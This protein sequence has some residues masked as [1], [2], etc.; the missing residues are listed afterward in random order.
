MS[1]PD[2]AASGPATP[3]P[4]IL[5]TD[6]SIVIPTMKRPDALAACLDR[7]LPQLA[8][9]DQIIVSEDDRERMSFAALGARYPG[10]V[11]LPGPCRGPAANRNHGARAATRPWLLFLDDDCLPEA[12][13]LAEYRRVIGQTPQP[14]AVEGSIAA[15][16]E[17]F[18]LASVSPVN[19]G[20]GK[21]WTCNA[22]VRRDV[23]WQI[24]GFDERFPF[25]AMEDVDLFKR[26]CQLGSPIPFAAAARVVHPWRQQR[27]T[28]P[29]MRQAASMLIYLRKYPEESSRYG[30]RFI[31]RVGMRQL[32]QWFKF[33]FDR[34]Y[35]G[36]WFFLRCTGQTFVLAACSLTVRSRSAYLHFVLR[37]HGVELRGR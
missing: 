11:W 1:A 5:N 25:A 9:G 34:R 7:L 30:T 20:G 3:I 24:D 18:D 33:L 2:R 37:A 19:L 35:S 10:M 13:L 21:F 26:L 28:R 31:L 27:D 17:C 8:P 36:R 4:T 32:T 16:R 6:L 15:D 29:L 12:D 23:F 14:I 22:A